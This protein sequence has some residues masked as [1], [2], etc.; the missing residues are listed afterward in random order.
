MKYKARKY[1]YSEYHT[2]KLLH[3]P[4]IHSLY[5]IKS[6]K[7]EVNRRQRDLK[8]QAKRKAELKEENKDKPKRLGKSK[9]PFEIREYF[10]REIE[11]IILLSYRY[12]LVGFHLRLNVLISNC[13]L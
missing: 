4:L 7:K 3:S 5:R 1:T 13:R 12:F 9:Y 8:E 11:N 6:I 2:S 10:E